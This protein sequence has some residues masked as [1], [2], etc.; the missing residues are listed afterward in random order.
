MGSPAGNNTT[1]YCSSSEI[2]ISKVLLPL[3]Q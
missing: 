2:K 1:V 3:C